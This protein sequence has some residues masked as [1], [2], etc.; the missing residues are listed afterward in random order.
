MKE[1]KE[2]GKYDDG[3]KKGK[4]MMMEIKEIKMKMMEKKKEKKR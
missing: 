1:G 2:R 4:E 3:N